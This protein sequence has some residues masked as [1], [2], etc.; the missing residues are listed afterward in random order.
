MIFNNASKEEL[1]QLVLKCMDNTRDPLFIVND[2]FKVVYV[3]KSFENFSQKKQPEL[4]GINFGNALGCRYLD[5][6]EQACGHNYYCELCNIREAIE[7]S[8]SG[9]KSV[10]TGDLVRD[11]NLGNEIVFRHIIF[12]SFQVQLA[13][14]A[15]A[16]VIF[17]Q[18]DAEVSEKEKDCESN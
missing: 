18:S 13:G 1:N 6:G 14:L 2:Q 15:Y 4:Y 12:K 10:Y 9:E 5:K 3:N 17:S 8:L 7:V 11:F 16:V